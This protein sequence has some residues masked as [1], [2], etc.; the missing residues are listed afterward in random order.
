MTTGNEQRLLGFGAAFDSVATK[1]R[2]QIGEVSGVPEELLFPGSTCLRCRHVREVL[3]VPA[4]QAPHVVATH[5]L[6][7]RLDRESL[8]RV[9]EVVSGMVAGF[10][11][12]GEVVP[13]AAE[14][15]AEQLH[16][17]AARARERRAERN[18]RAEGLQGHG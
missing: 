11:H 4:E 14:Q 2:T 18:H 17:M 15:T 7:Y 12:L 9:L 5:E 1:I 13:A 10:D 3:K 16:G 8:P 6:S